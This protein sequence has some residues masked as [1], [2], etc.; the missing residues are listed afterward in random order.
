MYD[1][2]NM[3]FM[4][5]FGCLVGC[6]DVSTEK[7]HNQICKSCNKRAWCVKGCEHIAKLEVTFG[8]F[9]L[10]RTHANGNYVQG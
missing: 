8:N 10:V 3:E 4:F 7:D 5:R 1:Y 2:H 6:S 9:M